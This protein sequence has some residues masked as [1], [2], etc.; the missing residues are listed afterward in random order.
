MTTTTEYVR[1]PC[2]CG[3]CDGL[4]VSIEELDPRTGS[5]EKTSFE[6]MSRRTDCP[7][8]GGINERYRS[9]YVAHVAELIRRLGAHTSE[10]RFLTIVLDPETAE[11]AN[12]GRWDDSYEVLTGQGGVWTKARTSPSSVSRFDSHVRGHDHGSPF[13]WSSACPPGAR[14]QSVS[15]GNRGCTSRSGC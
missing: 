11:E 14:D 9:S 8:C 5:L 7:V 1:P 6:R 12:I 4:K 2:N 15:N 13:R 3:Y 10:V